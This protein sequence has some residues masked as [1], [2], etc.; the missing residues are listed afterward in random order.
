[1][2]AVVMVRERAV[3]VGVN[4][5]VARMTSMADLEAVIAVAPQLKL[6]VSRIDVMRGEGFSED[7][8]A[9]VLTFVRGELVE[10]PCL[11]SGVQA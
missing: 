3:R 4:P 5:R 9:S 8:I 1:M 11:G 6:A 10:A 2:S 7:E